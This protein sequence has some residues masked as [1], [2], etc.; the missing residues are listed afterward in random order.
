MFSA[1]KKKSLPY[2]IFQIENKKERNENSFGTDEKQREIK[3]KIKIVFI[4]FG[5]VVRF[6]ENFVSQN[7]ILNF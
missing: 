2:L 5:I 3:F 1:R 6:M 7:E 4:S